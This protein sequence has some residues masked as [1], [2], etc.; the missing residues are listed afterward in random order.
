MKFM[1]SW[2]HAKVGCWLRAGQR[3]VPNPGPSYSLERLFLKLEAKKALLPLWACQA[4]W[5]QSLWSAG[6]GPDPAR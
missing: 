2:G 6:P 4:S 1:V 5:Q 3:E